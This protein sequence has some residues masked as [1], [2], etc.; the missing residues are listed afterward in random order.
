VAQ[1]ALN[2]IMKHAKA[3]T[4]EVSLVANKESL[5]LMIE[6]NG[7]GFENKDNLINSLG[8]KSMRN[9]IENLEGTFTIDTMK[10]RGTTI[11]AEIPI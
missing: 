2:N 3:T 7:I 8:L 1:E 4:V 10:N 5:V 11:I 9:R 6:D